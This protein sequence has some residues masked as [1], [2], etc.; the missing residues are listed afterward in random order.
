MQVA[1][2]VAKEEEAKNS[3]Y[4]SLD[5]VYPVRG[6][7]TQGILFYYDIDKSL[8]TSDYLVLIHTE[9]KMSNIE[10]VR[11][12]VGEVATRLDSKLKLRFVCLSHSLYNC[13][14]HF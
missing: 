1:S 6:T 12:R 4:P 9:S 2:E 7:K 14:I 13:V 5:D 11:M 8:E 3:V 10:D